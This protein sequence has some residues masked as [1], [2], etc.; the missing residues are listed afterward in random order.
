MVKQS[1]AQKKGMSPKLVRKAHVTRSTEVDAPIF[2]KTTRS[3]F[4]QMSPK[5]KRAVV[6]DTEKKLA[7]LKEELSGGEMVAKRQLFNM[8]KE[9]SSAAH[10]THGSPKMNNKGQPV[11][12]YAPSPPGALSPTNPGRDGSDVN[13][14]IH[15]CSPVTRSARSHGG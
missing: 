7:I 10:V 15:A 6:D 12:R 2:C 9:G 11:S 14:R 3:K 13:L 4:D 5:S 8:S 1:R